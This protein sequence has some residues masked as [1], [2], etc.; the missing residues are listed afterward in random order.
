MVPTFPWTW[1]LFPGCISRAHPCDLLLLPGP[2]IAPGHSCPKLINRVPQA[3]VST[4]FNCVLFPV[5]LQVFSLVHSWGLS[6]LPLPLLPPN[7]GGLFPLLPLYLGGLVFLFLPLLPLYL[8]GLLFLLLPLFLLYL[9]ELFPLLPLYLGGL[10]PLLPLYLGGLVF[11][12]LPLFPLYLGE[13]FPLLP[14]YLRGLAFL[15][16]LFPLLFLLT[17]S[18]LLRVP[19]TSCQ[20]LHLA[21]LRM[22]GQT[23]LC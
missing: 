17:I 12:L 20:W 3:S 8:G 15:L 16:P 5:L 21:L 19:V 13:L 18:Q 10:F 2:R 7:P 1:R 4:L 23:L 11:L 22:P 9:G 6:F 14:L